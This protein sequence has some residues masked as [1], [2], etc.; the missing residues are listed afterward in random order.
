MLNDI[1]IKNFRAFKDFSIA[2]LAQANLI[3]GKNNV[4]KSSLLEAAHL[5]TGPS[6]PDILISLLE[7]R[8]EIDYLTDKGGDTGNWSFS[9]RRGYDIAHLFHGH[10]LSNNA[11]ISIH[12]NEGQKVTLDYILNSGEPSPKSTSLTSSAALRLQFN[13]QETFNLEAVENIIEMQ[14]YT[15][16]RNL[17]SSNSLLISTQGF[18][19]LKLAQF[20]DLITLTP[21][22]DSV[23]EMLQILDPQINRISFQSLKGPNS[24]ILIKRSNQDF[25]I[26]LGSLGDGI[27][28][29]MAIASALVS[30]ENG[31][32]FIDEIDTGL[33]Y[34]AI[35][36]LWNLVFKT[37]A[38]LNIQVFATTHSSDCI[39]SFQE[40]LDMQKD[41]SLGRLFRLEK[42]S[43]NIVAVE[44]NNEDLAVATQQEIEVR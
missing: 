33:H 13:S 40:A 32:L 6:N 28:R 23:V 1:R 17:A 25:P 19:F 15:T 5:L 4:G 10:H 8:G 41:P 2:N 44:Y 34:R 22:E 16:R 38:K 7:K 21:K 3:V 20:W 29:V 36:D 42:R 18:D 31:Y 12:S 27:H 37:A 11:H 24:G 9:L 43:N 35:A 30:A 39:D 26:P 14:A